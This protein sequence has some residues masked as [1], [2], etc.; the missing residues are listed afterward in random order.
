M[1]RIAIYQ[2][3]SGIDP[4]RNAQ[5][6]VGAVEQARAGGAAMLFTRTRRWLPSAKRRASG[7]CGCTSAAWR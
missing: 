1:T 2:A 3:Q 6:L 5:A 4:G 7:D